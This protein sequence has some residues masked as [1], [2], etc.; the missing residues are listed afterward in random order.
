MLSLVAA[1]AVGMGLE[2]DGEAARRSRSRL[3]ERVR[4]TI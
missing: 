4:R 2:D 3:F 1:A